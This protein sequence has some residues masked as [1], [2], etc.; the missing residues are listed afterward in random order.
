MEANLVK[1]QELYDKFPLDMVHP[2][3]VENPDWDEKLV[4]CL[5]EIGKAYD[6]DEISDI[7]L[8]ASLRSLIEIAYVMG[9]Q[10]GKEDGTGN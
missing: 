10:K 5:I 9:H 3:V 2:L 7:G 6:N 4:P 8:A 1:T